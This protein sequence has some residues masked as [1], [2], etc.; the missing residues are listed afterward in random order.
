MREDQRRKARRIGVTPS[1]L[2][3]A[4]FVF[5]A[6]CQKT[7]MRERKE[8]EHKTV[9]PRKTAGAAAAAEGPSARAVS[10]DITKTPVLGEPEEDEKGEERSVS[11]A[12]AP[13]LAFPGAEGFGA[14]A[15]GGRGGRV[16]AVTNLND[17]GPGSLRAALEQEGPR[18]VVFRVS[19]TITLKSPLRLRHGDITIAGQTAPGDGICLKDY[20]MSLSGP[21]NVIIR[22]LRFRLGDASGKGLDALSGRDC[23]DFIIDH[24]SFSWSVDAIT[25][26]VLEGR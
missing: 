11:S 15:T 2:A 12:D 23:R 7:G 19:G 6:G 8:E 22:H 26:Q 14:S 18:T 5:L 13:P 4:C 20:H 10:G 3:A 24:C 9:A 17:E 16:I 1:A 21:R 25:V